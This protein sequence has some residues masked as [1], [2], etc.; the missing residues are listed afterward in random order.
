MSLKGYALLVTV[1]ELYDSSEVMCKKEVWKTMQKLAN[2]WEGSISERIGNRQEDSTYTHWLYLHSWETNDEFN[3]SLCMEV[4]HDSGQ[5]Y[6]HVAI[7]EE[8]RYTEIHD[9]PTGDSHSDYAIH[10]SRYDSEK[11]ALIAAREL[12]EEY[13]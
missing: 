6:H 3:S 11:E 7:F 1:G 9:Y 13:N 10:S 5:K 2:N 4:F 12:M 8:K